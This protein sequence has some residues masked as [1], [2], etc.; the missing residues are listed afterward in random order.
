M[1]AASSLE[2]GD[3]EQ[4]LNE[5]CT[6]GSALLCL[7]SVRH[8]SSKIIKVALVIFLLA[9]LFFILKANQQLFNFKMRIQSEQQLF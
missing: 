9:L 4:L 2:L 6:C 1:D 8:Q 5:N 7:I 3:D